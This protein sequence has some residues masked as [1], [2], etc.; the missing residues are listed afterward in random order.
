MHYPSFECGVGTYALRC[1]TQVSNCTYYLRIYT[2]PTCS[3]R[4]S[5]LAIAALTSPHS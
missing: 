5:A 3:N 4:L 1:I 2:T